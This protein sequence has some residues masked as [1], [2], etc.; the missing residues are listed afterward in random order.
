MSKTLSGL[1]EIAFLPH[2]KNYYLVILPKC[3]VSTCAFM[4]KYERGYECNFWPF[5]LPL[6]QLQ[7]L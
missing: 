3:T 4:L 2:P 7:C 1:V 6:I 5:L